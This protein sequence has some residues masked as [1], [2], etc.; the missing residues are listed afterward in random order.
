MTN[1]KKNEN[2]IIRNI[3]FKELNKYI[4][5]VGNKEQLIGEEVDFISNIDYVNTLYE[6][7]IEIA[8]QN[9]YPEA[10]IYAIKDTIKYYISMSKSEQIKEKYKSML[11]VL[12]C[13]EEY[14]YDYLFDEVNYRY[15]SLENAN[16]IEGFYL[17]NIHNLMVNDYRVLI[18]ITNDINF[19]DVSDDNYISSIRKFMCIY[20][21]LFK[22]QG[23]RKSTQKVLA[24]IEDKKETEEEKREIRKLNRYVQAC[25]RPYFDLDDLNVYYYYSLIAG[26]ITN[27]N[28]RDEFKKINEDEIM[29]LTFLS[30]LYYVIKEGKNYFSDQH[31]RN[32]RE[33][34]DYV[35]THYK[36]YFSDSPTQLINELKLNLN[37][38]KKADIYEYLNLDLIEANG[39]K[40]T[41]L[42]ILSQRFEPDYEAIKEAYKE[43]AND[44]YIYSEILKSYYVS[45]DEFK[46]SYLSKF[47][48]YENYIKAI[49]KLT[50][51]YPSIFS[52]DVV[53]NRTKQVF[54]QK[55]E[56]ET[57]RKE[58]KEY[59]KILKIMEY[60]N[61]GNKN[62]HI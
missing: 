25:N 35:N 44:K 30:S 45:E 23:V 36:K 32:L 19:P 38:S 52:Q 31:I 21:E 16:K 4:F 1:R 40:N 54:D 59:K 56:Q 10:I 22:I 62:G 8:R 51:V 13:I 20:P 42:F 41:I 53:Y 28:F 46:N 33:I 29:N 9:P 61:G 2:I 58:K 14:S 26:I 15:S 49:R 12:N 7:I 24:Q 11:N 39:I 6:I 43:I 55:L 60:Y 27:D 17:K 5:L 18:T 47:I 48:D 37:M 57:D 50:N 3:L 34:V